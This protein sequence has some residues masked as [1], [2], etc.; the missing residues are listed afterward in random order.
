MVSGRLFVNKYPPAWPGGEL[1]KEDL[2][3]GA[4]R[5]FQSVGDVGQ[6]GDLTGALD[7]LGQLALMRRGRIL[8]RSDVNRRS[9]AASL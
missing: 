1:Q 6:Q 7:G 3:A 5:F 8:A 2:S 4:D 9:L